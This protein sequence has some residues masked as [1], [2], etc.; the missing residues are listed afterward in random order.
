MAPVSM[1]LLLW[2]AGHS[3]LWHLAQQAEGDSDVPIEND[4]L[5]S[6]I[7]VSLR[8]S[9]NSTTQWINNR[10]THPNPGGNK[11]K[12][13][14]KRVTK[15]RKSHQ[16]GL[17]DVSSN[18]CGEK[19]CPGWSMAPKT[20]TCTRAICTP[21]CKNRGVCRKPQEC[22]CKVGFE[23][24]HCERRRTP[25]LTTN[26]TPLGGVSIS[27]RPSASIRRDA[28]AIA[29]DLGFVTL[30]P[31]HF[32][33]PPQ[34]SLRSSI[35]TKDPTGP[36][37]T[38]TAL[39]PG[40]NQ[41]VNYS[42]KNGT[43]LN[44]QPLTVQ[45]LQSILQR[46]G[47]AKEDKMTALLAKHLETQKS[48]TTKESWKERRRIP[49]SIRTARGEYNI[50]RQIQTNASGQV[51]KVRVM[52]TPMI[53]RVHC[54]GDRC[55]NQC[56]KGNM[57]TVYS[58]ELSR[59]N[60]EHGFRA[61]LCPLLC[62]N[63]GICIKKDTCLCPPSFTGKF[64][65]I[66][67]STGERV[68]AYTIRNSSVE[69]NV[70]SKSS[71]YTLPLSNHQPEKDGGASIVKVHVQHPPEASV[72]I[73]QVERVDGRDGLANA[74]R[75]DYSRWQENRVPVYRVQAQ[76]SPR[77]NGYTENSGYGYCYRVL[78][79]GQCGSPFPGLRTQEVCCRGSGVAWGVH[80]C[81]PCTGDASLGS[82]PQSPCPKGFERING[83]C[84]DIDE[85]KDPAL[86]QNGDCTNTRGSF[87][88]LCKEGYL[89]DSS[90]SS[91]ISHHV[92]SEA[93]GPCFRI[94]RDGGCSLPILRNI[95]KQICCCSRVG[96]AWGKGCESCPPFGTDGFKETCPAGPGYHYSASDLRINH[97]FVG[98]DQGRVPVLRQPGSRILTTT[99]SAPPHRPV[100]SRFSLEER[101]PENDQT[102]GRV[103]PQ[104]P[105][106][107]PIQI[108]RSPI[109][110]QRLLPT[111]SPP[112]VERV[113]T[114]VESPP[115]ET[116]LCELNP[117]ICGPGRCEPRPGSYTCVCN[118]GYWLSTQGTH[119]IDMDECRQRPSP[120]TNGRC[121]NT[122]GSYRCACSAGFS[123]NPQ[124]TECTDIDEC[125]SGQQLCTNGRCENTPGSYRCVCPSG[126]S[127]NA[128]GNTCVDIDECRLTPR[129]LCLNG[130]CENTPGSYR[131]VCPAGFTATPQGT[132]CQDIDECRQTPRPCG[133]GRCLNTPGSFRCS[134]PTGYRLTPQ[135][136]DCIDI[137]ECENPGA[138]AG[139]E[140]V[141]TPGSFQC[142]QCQ[143]GYRLQN[144]RCVDINE[145][146]TESSCGRNG[147]C[148]NTDGSYQCECAPG[149]RLSSDRTQCTDINECLEGD[150][151]FPR[152]ECQN[153][154][155]SY[156]CVCAEGYAT[157][158]DGSSCV[159]KD[160]CQTGTFCQGGRC[161]NTMGSFQCVCP[162]G[163][164]ASPDNT[165][166]IDI[167]ECQ[168]RG[169]AI[170]GTQTCENTLGS[171]RC[172]ASC[173]S[174]YR[175]T[176]SGDCADVNEC[177]NNSTICGDNAVCENLI[178]SYRCTCSWG[179]E[180][181]SEGQ[182][183]IDIDE[184]LEY[185]DSLCGSM[186]CQNTP[187]SYKC[188]SDCEPGY[189]LSTSGDCTDVDECMTLQGVCGTALCENVEG[190]FLCICPNS[191][192]EFDPMFGKCIRTPSAARHAY[193]SNTALT[194]VEFV[195]TPGLKECYYNLED[196]NVCE[197]VLSR[198]VSQV[199]CCCTVGKGWGQACQIQRCPS[200]ESAEYR[201]L[202]PLGVGYITS[203]QESKDIDECK[204]FGSELC[205][206][207]VCLNKDPLFA[208]YCSNGYYYDVH[209]LECVD[210]D[211]C[212][213]EEACEGG[214]CINTVG[215]Y[216][217]TC[218]PPLVLDSSLRRCVTNTSQAIEN[219]VALCW[220]TVGADLVCKRP[221]VDRQTT[222]TECCCLYGE[223]WGMNCAL[224]PAR[225][226]DDF[227]TLC[228][229]LRS[230]GYGSPG[231]QPV[232]PYEYGSEYGPG[233]GVPYGADSF[234]NPAPGIVRPGY[235]AY[236]APPGIGFGS[237]PQP[238]YG[239]RDSVYS[240]PPFESPDFD[241]D[242]SYPDTDLDEA[243]PPFRRPETYDPR[244][245]PSPPRTRPRSPGS[246][247]VGLEDGRRTQPWRPGS[248]EAD[249][250]SSWRGGL[251]EAYD[252]RY[253]QFE[254]LQAE[255]CGIL[256][257]CD[258]G[259]CIRVPEGYTCD[260]YDG[261]RLDM[262]RMACVD[263]NE[264]DEA[265]DLTLLC[266]NGQ[267]RNTEGS[268]ECICPRGFVRSRQHNYCV[269]SQE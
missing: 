130:R 247:G 184:C 79:N 189:Q 249:G 185:G 160:E 156:R 192:E 187:G 23:G 173:D 58:D 11:K 119:C 62:Q 227:E 59:N 203:A 4:I 254:G 222:Y 60:R 92:I 102:R 31:I 105:D 94:L 112:Q 209:H 139:Q 126:F 83:T 7:Y 190:S 264:C 50:L 145:C 252:D 100:T 114:G 248:P 196:P 231:P 256:N 223:A 198:N 174:G 243:R 170:C 101:R 64:C 234:A 153:T 180:L 88:C 107:T 54:V 95:T 250:L 213:E 235:E 136:S 6:K 233:Y 138:C 39:K 217:C 135:G 162:T 152:G 121:E 66:P 246:T 108:N 137:N 97:R 19:C 165:N 175:V 199:E 186:R 118:N 46:K 267:C 151:C 220:R 74:D 161:T 226:S 194:R 73:H 142:R 201:R 85:C 225:D 168:E 87:S 123:T 28:A 191:N 21:K 10:T 242:I 163:L 146:L 2:L 5:V 84:I 224:C 109:I 167:D 143:A 157:S 171:Y 12:L 181:I 13:I 129:R 127:L 82:L 57:T 197:N 41:M 80:D 116:N 166:C 195:S 150:F 257:G 72:N 269:P 131:C 38:I 36:V 204:L 262:T 241:S 134:C 239:P 49:N 76:S 55:T 117:Q 42:A 48:Q 1:T 159:D 230:P 56:E 98:Q 164:R 211:E 268:Y 18:H 245:R 40:D 75:R 51:E 237:R 24:S 25:P 52:F 206:G 141:N 120:C 91:C 20:G 115:Q 16:K 86:C 9:K 44:W 111:R 125:N 205:K 236:P 78:E 178:G 259:R 128:Q 219:T 251:R 47:F 212:Q 124:G 176:S 110:I 99:T 169:A 32:S 221:L 179:H 255:E 81:T 183:C 26:P 43:S 202:C 158:P 207:G 69:Q 140:C 61:F 33:S 96:K 188:I 154:E 68:V 266:L 147:R 8:D 133:S 244:L 27:T 113:E 70:M 218:N 132:D 65:Q 122:V 155:G 15:K 232:D 45:E 238:P 260:C 29:G 265:E 17:Q 149:F 214:N 253:E 229:G 182:H 215:S 200:M 14:L 210:N 148:I 106:R 228:N 30:S 34:T 37:P 53:C 258:N 77:I 67:V 240:L 208:C 93:K 90:R 104:S 144:R 193:P 177:A 35:D 261:Y 263:I 63:G 103:P 172:I 3:C 216:F 22:V 71:V 89:L